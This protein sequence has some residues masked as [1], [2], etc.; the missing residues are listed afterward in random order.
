MMKYMI[1]MGAKVGGWAGRNPPPP[2][3]RNFGGELNPPD[4]EKILF[5]INDICY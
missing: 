3:P 5:L 2:P 4:F 1:Y